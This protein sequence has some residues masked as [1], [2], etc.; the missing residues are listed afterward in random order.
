M[1]VVASLEQVSYRYPDAPRAALEDVSL[2]VEAGSVTVLHG[3][4]GG[5]KTTVLRALAG[6]VP[7]WHGGRFSGRVDR[8]GRVGMAFQDPESQAVHRRVLRDV[9]FGLEQIGVPPSRLRHDAEEALARVEAGHLA[10]R[11]L[12]ELSGGERQRVALAGVLAA[13]PHLLLLDEPTS[14]LDDASAATLVALLRRLADDGLAVVLSEHRLDRVSV[15]AD[16]VVGVERGR[17]ADDTPPTLPAPANAARS[18]GTIAEP[19]LRVSG[20][21][22]ARGGVPVLR[23]VDLD[24]PRA[25]VVALHGANGVGKTTLLRA[26]AGLERSAAGRVELRGTDLADVPPERRHPRLT[27]VPQDPGRHLLCERVDEE[28]AFGL[29]AVEPSRSGRD[30]RV[31]SALTALDLLPHRGRHPG[32]LSV[33]ERER[34]ALAVALA[35]EPE[36]LLLDE[37]TRGMDPG[38]RDALVTLLRRRA[39]R[40]GATLLATH[41]SR[42]AAAAADARFELVRG[43]ARRVEVRPAAVG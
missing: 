27:V 23:G 24:V 4:S 5:G 26:L 34:V 13:R 17:L 2:R 20:L 29:A 3:S 36:L 33:G 37:P 12:D 35:V 1:T 8:A 42:F 6:L 15:I 10:G 21:H 40:G 16:R 31:T 14:Q 30:R 7:T 32:D 22:V 25:S 19:L 41:D 9:V 38:R 39:E 18:R 28:I 11:L 43:E